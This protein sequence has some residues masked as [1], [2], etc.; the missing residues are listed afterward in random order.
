[1]NIIING[2][3][4]DITDAIRDYATKK[5]NT[6]RTFVDEGS[7]VVAD[8]GKTS[9]HHKSG[10]IFKAEIHVH[11]HGKVTRVSKEEE[12]L[13]AAIDIAQ[14]ELL[15]MLSNQKDK[16]NTLWRK[17]AQKIKAFAHGLVKK[18]DRK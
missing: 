14:G 2:S 6:L 11:S 4:I 9:N 16:K 15:D 5:L 7:K 3:H 8:L 10:D 12:D 13:Y 1:M 18:R 17:G